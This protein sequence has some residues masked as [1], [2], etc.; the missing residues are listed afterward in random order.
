MPR[1]NS[2]AAP[3]RRP[4]QLDL[5]GPGGW[6]AQWTLLGSRLTRWRDGKAV[7][8]PGLGGRPIC[9]LPDRLL[10][11][12]YASANGGIEELACYARKAAEDGSAPLWTIPI[13]HQAVGRNVAAN[14]LIVAGDRIVSTVSVYKKT[15]FAPSSGHLEIRKLADGSLLEQMPLDFATV[16]NGV[17]TD[18]GRIFLS[19][20]NGDVV[21][22]E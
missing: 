19:L 11:Q 17:A 22:L 9:L 5:T 16:D 10:V 3:Y 7:G 6:G 14:S 13:P 20:E 8:K 15:D 2:N 21:C 12:V 18:G 4:S 1:W